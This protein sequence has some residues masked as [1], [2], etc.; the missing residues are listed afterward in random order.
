LVQPDF[1]D[2]EWKTIDELWR[3]LPLTPNDYNASAL[4]NPVTSML[5][6]KISIEAGGKE[7]D[8]KFPDGCPTI[9]R[10]KLR[11]KGDILSIVLIKNRWKR[12][13]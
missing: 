3:A 13:R 10:I 11:G 7:F 8:E 1:N 9:V 6:K 2:K 12:V 4:N 5:M